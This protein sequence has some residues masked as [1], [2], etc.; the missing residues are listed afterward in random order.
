[1]S[2]TKDRALRAAQEVLGTQGIHG[3]THARVDAAAGLPK[4]STSNYFRTRA[5]LVRGVIDALEED[6]RAEWSAQA[7]DGF[8]LDDA[9]EALARTVEDSCGPHRVRTVARYALFVEGMHDAQ[10]AEPVRVARERLELWAA[11]ALE[12]FGAP[13]PRAAARTVLAYLDGVIL[14]R[15]AFGIADDPRPGLRRV[16]V[17]ALGS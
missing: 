7:G 2:P 4:G 13:D 3:L 10:V 1:M 12:A 6:E 11:A 15:L 5:A 17:A 8:G 16:L 9:V 14:H